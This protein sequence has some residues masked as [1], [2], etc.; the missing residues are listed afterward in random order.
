MQKI[1]KITKQEAKIAA[2]LYIASLFTFQDC[3][4]TD[5]R[6]SDVD[7][8]STDEVNIKIQNEIDLI[9]SKLGKGLEDTNAQTSYDCII[10]AKRIRRNK[11]LT[12]NGS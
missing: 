5:T 10:E 2:K 6:D 12:K 8:F 1:T 11:E 7:E 4:N 3:F 9:I